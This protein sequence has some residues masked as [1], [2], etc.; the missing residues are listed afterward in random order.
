VNVVRFEKKAFSVIGKEGSTSEGD[1]FIQRLWAEANAGFGEIQAM[2]KK[3]TQG[4]LI[5]IWGVMS[6]FSRSFR[7]W[8]DFRKGLYL[9]GAEC[10]DEAEAPEGWTKWTVPG[11]EYICVE[12]EG[13]ESFSQGLRYLEEHG[14]TLVGAVHDH[15]YPQTGKNYILYPIRRI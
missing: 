12:N 6:D 15:T 10:E 5:G 4:D 7:P 8:E 2:A 13:E 14:L 9:A 3:D 1:G 11:F